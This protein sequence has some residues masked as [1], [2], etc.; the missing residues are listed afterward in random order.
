MNFRRSAC[1]LR[2]FAQTS[3]SRNESGA[4]D[5]RERLR[6]LEADLAHINRLSMMENWPLAVTRNSAS[7]RDC[8]QQRPCGDE[9]LGNASAESE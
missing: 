4:Q 6:Q 2:S 9:V 7:D 1:Y 5:E 8:P 3:T